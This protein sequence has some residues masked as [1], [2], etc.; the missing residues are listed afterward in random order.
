MAR[1]S[2]KTLIFSRDFERPSMAIYFGKSHIPPHSLKS[3][4]TALNRPEAPERPYRGEK[5]VHRAEQVARRGKFIV[6][7]LKLFEI[8]ATFVLKFLSVLLPPNKVSYT[9]IFTKCLCHMLER[10]PMS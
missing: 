9:L 5:N 8:T 1:Y 6:G 10:A 7:L 4:H 3:V 2:G